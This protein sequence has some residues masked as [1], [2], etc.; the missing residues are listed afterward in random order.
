VADAVNKGLA[1]ARGDVLAVQSSDDG[2]LPG[3]VSRAVAA[4]RETPEVGLVY[5][6]FATIDEAGR[7][8]WRSTLSPY[9]LEGLLSKETWVP[10]PS[11]FFRAAVLDRLGGWDGTYFNCDTEFWL[12]LAFRYP[13]RKVEGLWAQR[14]RHAAQRNHRGRE[15]VAS[16]W[17]MV[18]RS[19]DLRRAAPPLRSAARCGAFLHAVR[20][21]P[22]GSSWRASANLWR[23][24]AARPQVLRRVWR[25]PLL[26]PGLLPLGILWDR[27][28][29]TWRA[30][31]LPRGA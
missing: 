15:I 12:R 22:G 10:Q 16:Y 2:Y 5:A 19:S 24:V 18:R 11:A 4:L 9:T 7:E 27:L 1:L 14:R 29:K 26:V 31:R 25:S 8:L 6:D 30:P 13:V 3:A 28:S 17:R 20:Y 23:A 21:N